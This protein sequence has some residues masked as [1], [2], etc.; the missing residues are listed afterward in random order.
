M[1]G[2]RK[3][4][5][6]QRWAPADYH[7]DEH[8]RLLYARR[9]WCTLTFYRTFLDRSHLAGGDLPADS[10]TLSALLSMPKRDVERALEFCLGRLIE[11][12]GDRLFQKRVRRDVAREI[13][14]REKQAGRANQRWHGQ[15]ECGGIASAKAPEKIRQSPPAPAPL[16]A[17][18]PAPAP[19]RTDRPPN[20]LVK[21]KRPD[22]ESR[23]Y[24]AINALRPL[25]GIDDGAEILRRYSS[26]KGRSAVRVETMTDD[27]LLRT[28]HDLEAAVSD[29]TR[30]RGAEFAG[31]IDPD[32]F[33][34]RVALR[35]RLAQ[36]HPGELG[37]T[38]EAARARIDALMDGGP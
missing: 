10:E 2:G 9:A 36:E 38:A 8:V 13:E 33:S 23:A 28:L 29:H 14:F 37:E 26:F 32:E 5:H 6:I 18:A 3:P 34:R 1:K 31:A 7:E 16:P 35:K 12:D 17:P 27:W 25:L 19:E 24:K 30:G 15:E 4:I 20:P 11:R 21:G 22:L